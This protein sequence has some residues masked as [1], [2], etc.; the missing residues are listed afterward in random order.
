MTRKTRF[1]LILF[2]VLATF[3]VL[4]RWGVESAFHLRYEA[5]EK[6]VDKCRKQT[7]VSVEQIR[8]LIAAHEFTRE[9][10]AAAAKSGPDA[11]FYRCLGEQEVF[12]AGFFAS[13]VRKHDI[14][15]W[16]PVH[17]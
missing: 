17:G 3:A 10:V 1:G 13:Y 8:A 9:T 11:S 15:P 14:A 16:A 2:A 4:Y 6:V 7:G 5:T 12:D